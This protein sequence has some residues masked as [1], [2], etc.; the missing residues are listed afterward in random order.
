MSPTALI[1]L[2]FSADW[3]GVEPKRALYD[4]CRVKG[5]VKHSAALLRSFRGESLYDLKT[6]RLPTLPSHPGHTPTH[7]TPVD[8]GGP[9]MQPIDSL[10][11]NLDLG[12]TGG[13][14]QRTIVS[15]Q[16]RLCNGQYLFTFPHPSIHGA[17]H[18]SSAV[19]DVSSIQLPRNGC[20]SCPQRTSYLP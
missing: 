1:Y 9:V 12:A 3:A 15:T 10:A 16:D 17:D 2:V 5:Q 8:R 4:C 6:R 11:L 18:L 20:V 19:S 7:L 14:N 13:Y